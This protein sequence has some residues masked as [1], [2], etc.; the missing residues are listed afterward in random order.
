MVQLLFTY[1]TLHLIKVNIFPSHCYIHCNVGL[2]FSTGVWLVAPHAVC[3]KNYIMIKSF[4]INFISG[5]VN[6][7]AIIMTH[8]VIPLS[9]IYNYVTAVKYSIGCFGLEVVVVGIEL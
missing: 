4:N 5:I 3:R 6:L 9:D 1:V 8:A 2:G 7:A